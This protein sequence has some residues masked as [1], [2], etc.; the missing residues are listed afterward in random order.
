[1]FQ[2]H[3]EHNI[4]DKGRLALPAAFRKHLHQDE[5]IAHVVMTIADQCLS[6]YPEKTW[7]VIITKIGNL[8]QLDNNVIALKRLIVGHAH[9]CQIDKAGRVLVPPTL[10]RHGGLEKDCVLI[11]QLDKIELWSHQRWQD[12][13]ASMSD[14]VS[15]IYRSLADSGVSL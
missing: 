11:G 2:G 10:R 12:S 7:N 8:N 3:Y 4:D 9:E 14:Q 13:F 6:I 5:G 1:M 15:D